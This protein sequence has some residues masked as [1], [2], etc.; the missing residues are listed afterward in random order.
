MMAMFL[1]CLR[2]VFGGHLLSRE[3]ALWWSRNER[4]VQDPPELRIWYGLGFRNTLPAYKYC[5]IEPRIDWEKLQFQSKYTDNMLFGNNVLRGQYLRRGGEVQAFFDL[6]KRLDLALGWLIKHRNKDVI[7]NRMVSWMVY[8]C[9]QQFRKDVLH[10]V[11]TEVVP[12]HQEEVL[13]AEHPFC[14][15]YFQNVMINGCYLI[16]GNKTDFKQVAD[17]GFF[18]FGS[19]DGLVREHWE[20]RP[21]RVLFRRVMAALTG[22]TYQATFLRRFWRS[23]YAHHWILPYPCSNALLQ[24]TKQRRRMWYS[25]RMTADQS[26]WEWARKD[27]QPGQP[28]NFPNYVT[29]SRDDWVTWLEDNG[30]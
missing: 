7:C 2:Y 6:T 30:L 27:W 17:L 29:W 28:D 23:L 10:A 16:S 21:F 11:S 19:D 9:L 13:K 4:T 14:Y 25:V 18:L 12:E 20:N 8:I 24:T 22:Q 5:W 3:S 1:R 15:E 26:E